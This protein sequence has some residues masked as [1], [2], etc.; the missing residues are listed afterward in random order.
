MTVQQFVLLC[1]HDLPYIIT[2]TNIEKTLV[3]WVVP[4]QWHVS[5]ATN[6]T[7]FEPQKCDMLKGPLPMSPLKAECLPPRQCLQSSEVVAPF[8]QQSHG[9]LLSAPLLT[10]VHQL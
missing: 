10:V 5:M 6:S 2:V 4:M 8:V 7:H 3:Q 1:P 9:Q